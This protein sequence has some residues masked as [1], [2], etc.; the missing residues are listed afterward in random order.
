MARIEKVKLGTVVVYG[1]PNYKYDGEAKEWSKTE[2][3]KTPTCEIL[4]VQE[5][6]RDRIVTSKYVLP[7][8]DATIT[9]GDDGLVYTYNC[10]LPYLTEMAHLAEV[11]K[12]IIVS[13]AFLYAGRNMPNNKPSLLVWVLVAA[14]ILLALVGMFQ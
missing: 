14:M 3:D 1:N 6:D 4:D 5:L 12:N 2:D 11:E 8:A 13:Q 10:S 9:T 7:L